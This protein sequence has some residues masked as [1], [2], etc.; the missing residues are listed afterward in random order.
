M[1]KM[2]QPVLFLMVLTVMVLSFSACFSSKSKYGC[3][4][5]IHAPEM[6]LQPVSSV[7]GA[8]FN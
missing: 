5:R 7:T 8:L 1:K 4:E 2:L 3:P 6:S